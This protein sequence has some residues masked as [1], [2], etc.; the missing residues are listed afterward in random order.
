MDLKMVEAVGVGFRTVIENREVV[1][2]NRS[3]IGS[4]RW[5][6]GIHTRNPHTGL[7]R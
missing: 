6:C 5:N 7:M 2:F 3:S 1:D 4:K